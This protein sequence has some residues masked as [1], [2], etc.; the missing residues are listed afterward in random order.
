MKTLSALE[1]LEDKILVNQLSD[2][3]SRENLLIAEILLHLIEVEKRRLFAEY[4]FS[5]MFSYCTKGLGL[6][7]ASAHRR[8]TS[9]RTIVKFPE[10]YQLVSRGEG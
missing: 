1:Q 9:A 5:S 2:L 6:T 4:G 8:I 10:V 3:L 7:E